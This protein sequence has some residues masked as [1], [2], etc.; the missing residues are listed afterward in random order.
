MYVPGRIRI[1]SILLLRQ[2]LCPLDHSPSTVN[3]E[4]IYSKSLEIWDWIFLLTDWDWKCLSSGLGFYTWS[5]KPPKRLIEASFAKRWN[6]WKWAFPK[7]VVQWCM[8][9]HM[10][11]MC[12]GK[13][14][15][16][17]HSPFLESLPYGMSKNISERLSRSWI[18]G[19]GESLPFNCH[20]PATNRSV[21]C[22][23]EIN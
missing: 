19:F 3:E 6:K 7:V 14:M 22:F 1:W 4:K 11:N 13:F 15:T 9:G 12:H 17:K 5:L 21:L 16:K 20:L 23:L 2:W 18:S 8:T 10:H